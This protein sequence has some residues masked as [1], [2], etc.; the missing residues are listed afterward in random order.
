MDGI[1][2]VEPMGCVVMSR[3]SIARD[4]RGFC[5]VGLS[6]PKTSANVGCVLRAAYCWGAA[7]VAVEGRRYHKSPTDTPKAYRHRPLFEVERLRE[8]I[9]YACAPVAIEKIDGAKLLTE[10][11]HPERAF[12]IFGPEDG[13]LG[14]KTLDWC[15]DVVTIPAGCLNLAAA[16]NVVLYDRCAKR[17]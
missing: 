17:G 5:C 15:R 16:V 11:Q 8:V 6:H 12:Y 3:R 1:P 7:F 13:S 2:C 10:Y 4:R 14:S 9:P